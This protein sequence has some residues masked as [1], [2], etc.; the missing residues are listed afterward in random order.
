[1]ESSRP[2]NRRLTTYGSSAKNSPKPNTAPVRAPPSKGSKAF[3]SDSHRSRP[4]NSKGFGNGK[5]GKQPPSSDATAEV[6]IYD[7]PL[8]DDEDAHRIM[9]RKRRRKEPGATTLQDDSIDSTH[10]PI[11]EKRVSTKESNAIVSRYEKGSSPS[12][13]TRDASRPRRQRAGEVPQP[14]LEHSATAAASDSAQK[15]L[16]PDLRL[17]GHESATNPDLNSEHDGN[18]RISDAA[19]SLIPR[20]PKDTVAVNGNTTPGRRRLV[21][22]LGMSRS[23]STDEPSSGLSPTS[24]SS[25]LAHRTATRLTDTPQPDVPTAS[26]PE[27]HGAD[28]NTAISPHVTGS[29]VTYARQRSFLDDLS[30]TDSLSAPNVSAGLEP[31]GPLDQNRDHQSA[32]GARLFAIEEAN[33]DEGSVRSIHELRR[34]GGNAR[35]REAIESIFEDIE[36]ADNS[37]SGRCSSLAQLC[38]KLLDS[39]FVR[40]FVECG[41]DKR[42]IDLVSP[43]MDVVSLALLFCAFGLSSLGRTLPYV[44]ATSVWPKLLETSLPLLGH[45]DEIYVVARAQGNKLSKSVQRLLQKDA[46][47]IKSALLGDPPALKLSP[48]LIV[49][50]CLRVTVSAFQAKGE[51]PTGLPTPWLRQ[52]VALLLPGS[53]PKGEQSKSEPERSRLLI[54]GLS[55]LEAHTVSRNLLQ[56]EQCEILRSLGN[57]HDLLRTEDNELEM[58]S[59]QTRSLY[60]RVILNVTNTNPTLCDDFATLAMIGGLVEVAMVNFDDLAA[61]S[62][63][64]DNNSLDTAILALGAL[65][66]LAEKS[67]ASR[68]FFLDSDSPTTQSHL[69]RLLGLFLKHFDSISNAHS[70]RE[71]HHNVVVGYLAVL[72]LALCLHPKA[73][74][75]VKESSPSS[76]LTE[77]LSTVDEFLQYHRKIERELHTFSAAETNG[78]HGRLQDLVSQIQ[79][80]EQGMQ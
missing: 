46:S 63:S 55:I 27:T 49:L 58:I 68:A 45:R 36:D 33:D 62:L 14:S 61:D 6:D 11:I 5:G 7:L 40:Q 47:E 35:Y 50:Q 25:P 19:P 78:F 53:S 57:M 74:S 34:A 29:R 79:R 12:K 13:N 70:V 20:S 48:C 52:L 43:N 60:L 21:D 51:N 23:R 4:S 37:A 71:V 41:F 38:G 39:N 75:Q 80:S 73:R 3:P 56:Q 69:K 9:R 22:S 64:Q 28:S 54:L 2:R 32:P 67:D 18:P 10:S 44:L 66:N 17:R 31:V 15:S 1:M 72:L 42:L 16:K 30:L 77:V 26:Q 76:G 8:S 24:P 65:I 59:Q